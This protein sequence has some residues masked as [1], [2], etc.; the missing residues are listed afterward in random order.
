MH[1]TLKKGRD[2]EFIVE[3][4]AANGEDSK[5]WEHMELLEDDAMLY[6]AIVVRCT[7]LSIDKP[8]LIY[9]SKECSRKMSC[10]QNGN[11]AAMKRIGWHLL[12]RPRIVHM[13][14]WQEQLDG[15]TAYGDSNWTA[16]PRTRKSMSGACFMHWSHLIRA[17]S[18]TQSSIALCSG[19][20]E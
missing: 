2:I 7:F 16:C 19:E 18:K 5:S 3:V 20:A 4:D 10:P 9:A 17:Y 1:K 14:R 12:S 8:D 15:I 11:L 6:R 13:F